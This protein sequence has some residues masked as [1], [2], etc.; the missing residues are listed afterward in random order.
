MVYERQRNVICCLVITAILLVVILVPTS[1]AYLEYYEYGLD[2]RKTTGSVNTDKV[3]SSGRYLLGID[4]RFI[5]YKADAHYEF[6]DQ[7]SVFSAGGN[8]ESIGLEFQVDVDFTYF[9]IKDEIGDLHKELSTNYNNIIVSRAKDAIKNAAVSVTFTE[10]FQDR[11]EVERRFREAIEERWNQ[12]PSVHCTLDQFHLGRIRIPE[13]VATKQLQSRVQIER[14]DKEEYLQQAQLER[15]MTAVEVNSINLESE[16]VLRVA[17]A[18]ASLIRAKAKAEAELIKAQAGIAGTQMLLSE[19]GI[20]SQDH[21]SAFT[22]IRTLRER[23]AVDIDVSYLDPA[24]VLRTQ[25][26]GASS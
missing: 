6:L 21:M 23:G 11:T 17:Q 14:N 24:S 18:E 7:L 20:T 15:E 1:L 4:H 19:A 16:K 5:K 2:Q 3:Y 12:P 13:S 8:S 25:S 10:Y 22:Y 9:L 26:I